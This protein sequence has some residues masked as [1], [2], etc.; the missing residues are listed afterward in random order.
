MSRRRPLARRSL[1]AIANHGPVRY[2][3]PF[4]TDS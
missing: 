3:Y 4:I 2:V 1:L